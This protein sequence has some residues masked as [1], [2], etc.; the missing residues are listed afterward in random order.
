MTTY[1]ATTD[2]KVV[3]LTIFLLFWM[4]WKLSYNLCLYVTT[5]SSSML[6][7]DLKIFKHL[8]ALTHWGWVRHICVSRLTITGPDNGLSPGRRQAI[9]W[10]NAGILLI[11]PL[12]SNFSE[13]LIEILTFSF[14]KM[15]LKVS[16]AKWRPFCLGLNVLNGPH[17][18][19]VIGIYH[20]VTGMVNF[21]PKF[22]TKPGCAIFMTLR[23]WSSEFCFAVNKIW[24]G[25]YCTC[26]WPSIRLMG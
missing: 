12:G 17:D 13:M 19:A 26:R 16:S 7:F 18:S 15:R 6:N 20:V 10:T 4:I 23:S 24:V 1:S 14:T 9:I 25:H 22:W 21:W 11:W 8:F 2:N 3:Q 5:I